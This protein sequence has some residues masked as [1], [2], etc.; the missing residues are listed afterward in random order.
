[1]ILRV[2]FGDD[3]P[4][5]RRVVRRALDLTGSVPRLVAMT[6][7]RV[8]LGPR[9]PY[10]AFVRAVRDIDAALAERIAARRRAPAAEPAILDDLLAAG[11][12][13]AEAR[14]HLVTVLAAGHETTATALAWA[15]ERLAR[16]PDVVA[17]I[18]ADGA[19]YLDAVVK[20]VL[21]IRPVLSITPRRV[22]AP[23][24]IAGHVL[25][26]G[27]DVAPCVWLAHN[28]PASFPDPTAFRPERWL[29]SSP[30]RGAYIPWGGGV[31]R[32]AG[33]AFATM[34]LRE[35]LRVVCERVELTP[36]QPGD[37]RVRRR[38]VTLA[39]GRGAAVRART[40]T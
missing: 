24:E 18:R 1:V 4:E 25:A 14:D 27:V 22:V 10:G 17:R 32:C 15:L 30:E 11:A 40:V 23:F 38:S 39:P 29:E 31:R 3:D 35:V 16:R 2:T 9:S 6:L 7:L 26:P 37:E 28:D 36:A 13:D 33:V 12:D 21:R 20:E 34:E 8:D 19:P 5:L